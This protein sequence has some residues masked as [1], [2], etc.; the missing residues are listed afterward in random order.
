MTDAR[1]WLFICETRANAG[2]ASL[3]A[4][5]WC[6]RMLAEAADRV[7]PVGG[8]GRM[9]VFADGSTLFANSGA[10]VVR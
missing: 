10:A 7:E 1:H 4:D 5:P 2:Y 9:W 3:I 8:D 6:R